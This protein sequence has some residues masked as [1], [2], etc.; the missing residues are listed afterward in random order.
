MKN[1]ILPLIVLLFLSTCS[2]K[3]TPPLV[4]IPIEKDSTLITQVDTIPISE[5][6]TDTIVTDSNIVI[7]DTHSDS[8]PPLEEI[9]PDSLNPIVDNP[10]DTSDLV[11]EINQDSIDSEILNPL[12]TIEQVVKTE[13]QPIINIRKD[14]NNLDPNGP[15]ITAYKKAVQVMKSRPASDPT[16]WAYQAAIH[17][18]NERPE[19]QAWN[20]C[21]HQSYFFLSWHRMFLYYFERIAREASGDS[22]F[23]VPYWNYSDPANRYMPDPFRNPS[24]ASNPLYVS[25]RN[26]GINEG[27]E[28][29]GSATDITQAFSFDNFTSPPDSPLSFGG[30][31]ISQ[32]AHFGGRNGQIEQVPHNIMHV[33][34]GGWMNDPNFAALDPIFWCHHANIDRLWNKW[35]RENPA[36]ENPVSDS[37]WM[38]QEFEFF[39]EKGKLVTMSGKEIINTAEQLAYDYDDAEIPVFEEEDPTLV[40]AQSMVVFDSIIEPIKKQILVE[41]NINLD[42]N[43]TSTRV[44]IDLG[45]KFKSSLNNPRP[46]AKP[47]L[48][49]LVLQDIVYKK[50]PTGYHEVY[51]NLPNEI[52]NPDYQSIYYVG[53]MGFFGLAHDPVHSHHGGGHGKS[54]NFEISKLIGKQMREGIWDFDKIELTFYLKGSVIAPDGA[55]QDILERIKPDGNIKIGKILIEQFE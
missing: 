54:A 46:D 48:Y 19:K 34:I 25:N 28:L 53:S 43:T 26:I 12:D 52:T 39:D 5:I 42:C 50:M 10:V 35:L 23:V 41:A 13:D 49:V 2:K 18:S 16:S 22:T 17:G 40:S 44:P 20:N 15:E 9:D 38:N 29:P 30:Q 3:G 47:Q 14:I 55:S 4:D 1:Q 51:I 37:L 33:V 45:N 7:V 11:I 21:Q 8:I 27:F 6:I 31:R 32:T 24:D 36:R